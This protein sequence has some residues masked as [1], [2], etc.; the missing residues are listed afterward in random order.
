MIKKYKMPRH[1]RVKYD[2]IFEVLKNMPIFTENGELKKQRDPVWK[3]ACKIMPEINVHNLYL[4]V[5]QDRR[6]IK[7]NL[8]KH[9]NIVGVPPK[10]KKVKKKEPI[11]YYDDIWD[12]YDYYETLDNE[13]NQETIQTD[14]SSLVNLKT[15]EEF[16]N[17]IHKIGILPFSVHYWHPQQVALWTDLI[18]IEST[19]SFIALNNVISNITEYLETE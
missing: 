6:Q 1:A 14:F 7:T 16:K 5:Y 19:V 15:K 12:N 18:N 4:F 3:E 8:M 9:L 10:N 2:T 11:E 17:S 13:D